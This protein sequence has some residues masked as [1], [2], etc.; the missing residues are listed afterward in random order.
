MTPDS[1]TTP[2]HTY[3]EPDFTFSPATPAVGGV[4]TFT[5]SS[6]CYDA[7][8]NPYLCNTSPANR[9]QWDFGDGTTCDS[10]INPLCLGTVTST[11]AT[12][13]DKTVRLSVTDDL[14]TCDTTRTVPVATA[15]PLP[16]YREVAPTTRLDDFLARLSN[17]FGK[18]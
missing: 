9:Y 13:G 17:I 1:F 6:T 2:L 12:T 3:P 8:N 4:V 7:T 18:F 14:G 15:L 11:Y 16:E 5:D 10:T